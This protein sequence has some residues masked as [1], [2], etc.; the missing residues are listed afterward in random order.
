MSVI[1]AEAG[2][3][4][5]AI[6]LDYHFCGNDGIGTIYLEWQRKQSY[7]WNATTP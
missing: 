6:V 4:Y 5:V 2:I 3:Q 7:N 1:P